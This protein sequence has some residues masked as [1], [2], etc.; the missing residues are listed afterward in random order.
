M[1][2]AAG[3]ETCMGLEAQILGLCWINFF[4]EGDLKEPVDFIER[5]EWDALCDVPVVSV[6]L[7]DEDVGI[8]EEIEVFLELDFLEVNGGAAGLSELC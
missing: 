3:G 1:V 2:N 5:M 4:G 7:N 6:E 8:E